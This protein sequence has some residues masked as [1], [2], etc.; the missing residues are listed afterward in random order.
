V[1]A[2]SALTA[3]EPGTSGNLRKVTIVGNDPMKAVLA[4]D[5]IAAALLVSGY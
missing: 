2:P 4:F 1:G 3:A 5:L